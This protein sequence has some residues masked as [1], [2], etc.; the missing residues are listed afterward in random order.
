MTWVPAAGPPGRGTC[1]FTELLTWSKLFFAFHTGSGEIPETSRH[2]L[3]RGLSE[4]IRN[5]EEFMKD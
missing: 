2:E 3:E 4:A 5:A 1:V